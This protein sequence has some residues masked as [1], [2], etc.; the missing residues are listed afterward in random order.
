VQR[1]FVQAIQGEVAVVFIPFQKTPP[2]KKADHSLA[3]GV[4]YFSE[5]FYGQR[6]VVVKD[7]PFRVV[8]D[9]YS[10]QKQLIGTQT[11]R[12]SQITGDRP[13]ACREDLDRG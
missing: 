8:P 4:Q 12:A 1:I 9:I 2:L 7:K 3:D 13:A 11:K 5:L 10:T 6:F